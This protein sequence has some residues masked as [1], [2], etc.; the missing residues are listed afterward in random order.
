MNTSIPADSHPV[1][2]PWTERLP[3]DADC[4]IIGGGFSGLM[5]LVHLSE[6]M[7]KARIVL[8]ERRTTRTPGVAYGA[9]EPVHLLNVPAGRMGATSAEPAEYHAWLERHFPGR[10]Q[11][12]DFTPRQFYGRY[13]LE[14]VARRLAPA[15]DRVCLVSEAVVHLDHAVDGFELLTASGRTCVASTVV[16]APGIPPARAPWSL[17]ATNAPRCLLMADPWDT[18]AFDGVPADAPVLVVGSG[19]TAIDVVLGLRERGHRGHITMVSRNGRLPLPHALPGD[20]PGTL[21]PADVA[22]GPG[23]VMAVLRRLARERFA[24]GQSWQG[25]LDAVRPHTT[26]IWASWTPVQRQRFLRHA[27]AAWEVH[28]HRVPRAV[29]ARLEAD[30]QAGTLQLARG[31]L[32]HLEGTPDGQVEATLRRVDGRTEPL[33]AAR[34]F[35]CI[36]PAMSVRQTS[37]P[38][39]RSLLLSGLASSDPTGLGLRADAYGHVLSEAG[40]ADPRLFLVG[41]LRRGD[42]WEST[43]VPELR[44]Q[45]ERAATSVAEALAAQG[46][47]LVAR[48]RACL[49]PYAQV[50]GCG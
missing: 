37:D 16:L 9:C 18:G 33:R 47:G 34:V 35:N 12:S 13:L 32:T 49:P 40:I 6:R 30:L 2:L 15:W 48:T 29:L 42:L 14:V 38:L 4:A 43:A 11:P 3:P 36:G 24:K 39:L 17:V 50:E 22:G 8:L 31:V 44:V 46:G 25:A 41:A 20:T 1:A 19:L 45:C 28:R 23:A 27:R 7:P 10:F 26:A 5:T 21:T